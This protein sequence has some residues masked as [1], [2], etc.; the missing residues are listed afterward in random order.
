[1]EIGEERE[2]VLL[3]FEVGKLVAVDNPVVEDVAAVVGR[4]GIAVVVQ[5]DAAVAAQNLA[6]MHLV[7]PSLAHPAPDSLQHNVEEL[8][9]PVQAHE[10]PP[11]LL[12]GYQSL[13]A[14]EAHG[15]VEAQASD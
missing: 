5:E 3:D 7:D 15:A 12:Q 13:E 14:H 9:Q 4:A 11:H 2:F 6:E 10:P 8:P 1:M